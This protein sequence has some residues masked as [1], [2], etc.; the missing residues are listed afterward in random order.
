[1][2]NFKE[3][4]I[5]QKGLEIAVEVYKLTQHFPP[6]ERFGLT[7][8]ITRA[9]V[10]ISSNIAE[11]SSRKSEKDYY[12]FIEI[13]L[14]SIYELETQILLSKMIGYADKDEASNLLNNIIEEQRMLSSFMNTLKF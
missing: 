10:S 1:M 11:G 6:S 4:K 3:L 5:W 12:R 8:Q 13:A 2:R 9:A 14:G 7:S